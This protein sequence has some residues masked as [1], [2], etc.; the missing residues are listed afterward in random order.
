MQSVEEI[1][2]LMKPYYKSPSSTPKSWEPRE[3]KGLD[4]KKIA[5]I[6]NNRSVELF[7]YIEFQDYLRYTLDYIQ[8]SVDQAIIQHRIITWTT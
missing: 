8:D 5:N 7:S 1:A 2:N 6:I 4:A 3:M